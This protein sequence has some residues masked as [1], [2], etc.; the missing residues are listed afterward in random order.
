M[1]NIGKYV[2]RM[3][4]SNSVRSVSQLRAFVAWIW[5]SKGLE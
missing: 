4:Y 5:N 3:Y 2:F 1:S